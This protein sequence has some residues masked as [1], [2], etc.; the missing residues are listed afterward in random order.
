VIQIVPSRIE[1]IPPLA[2]AVLARDP[3]QVSKELAAPGGIDVN[4]RVR[5]R[6]GT[7]A[8]FTPLIL[9]ASISDPEIT[10]MLVS[11]GAKVDVFDDFHRSAFWYA[12]LNESIDVTYALSEAAGAREAVNAA[13][14]DLKRTPLHLAVRSNEPTIVQLL[15]RVGASREERDILEETPVDYCKRRATEACGLLR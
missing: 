5:A 12:A 1:Y 15:L 14:K 8:G 7:P 10:K 4:E 6:E 3:E 11:R 2:R 9:A 13:D